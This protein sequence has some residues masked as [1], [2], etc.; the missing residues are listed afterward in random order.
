L[1]DADDGDRKIRKAT[2][3]VSAMRTQV[4][5]FVAEAEA[6]RDRVRQAPLP[7]PL[8]QLAAGASPATASRFKSLLEHAGASVLIEPEAPSAATAVGEEP[9]EPASSVV[10]DTPGTPDVFDQIRRL[11]E[12][13]DAG[14]ITPGE[15]DAKK[16]ELLTRL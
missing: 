12:L 4:K 1:A 14:L 2:E 13:R 10:P 3:A 16:A 7:L 9:I 15:F 11:G 6:A 8:P 5:A